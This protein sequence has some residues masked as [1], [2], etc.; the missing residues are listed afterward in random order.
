MNNQIDDFESVIDDVKVER[1][2]SSFTIN[3]L[4]IEHFYWQSGDIDTGYPISTS[5]E[6]SCNYNFNLQKNEWTKTVSHTYYKSIDSKETNVY[7]EKLENDNIVKLIEQI[8]LRD[9]NNNYFTEEA[10]ERF[11]HWEITYNYY[12]KIV[13]TYDQDIEAFK[14]ISEILHFKDIMNAETKK[15]QS[16]LA[17]QE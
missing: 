10:P 8:D 11:T 7:S 4:K 2:R 13:G 1:N 9:L 16:Q 12:F 5:I 6:L 15:I 3:Q 17:Q 14:K